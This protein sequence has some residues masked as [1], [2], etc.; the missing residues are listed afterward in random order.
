MSRDIESVT[1]PGV[2]E[3]AP[4]EPGK[5]V[6]E[7]TREGRATHPVKM[8]S[9]EN[10]L[11]PS[12]AGLEAIVADAAAAY[13]Y[14]EMTTPD[15]RAA[16][17][18]VLG[19]SEESIITGNGADGVIYSLGMT[20]LGEGDEAVIPAVTFPVYA[21]VVRAMRARVV[22]SRMDG[23][24]I[25][26]DDVLA[27]IG[28]RTRVLWICNPNNPTGTI[29]ESDRF[30]RFLDR[31]PE[32]VWVVHDEVYHD[33]AERRTFPDALSEVRAGRPNLFCIRSFSKVYGL[34]G[35][36]LGF[37]FGPAELIGLMYRVRPPFDVS[38]MAE[39]AGLAAL[40]DK[41][42]YV[43]TVQLVAEGR[44]FLY[45]ELERLGLSFVPSH[46]NF[47]LVDT[48]KNERQVTEALIDRGIIVRPAGKYGL[49]GHIRVTV[50]LPDQNRRFVEALGAVL[51][52]LP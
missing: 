32:D 11:G 17:A 34:A 35:L 2:R 3:I 43:R 18:G 41:D 21:T 14:P 13:R 30:F 25:D 37:G 6:A 5:S 51:D 46:T 26:L 20:V 48:G 39:K 45:G 19:L 38:V 50:G 52:S 24:G 40:R 22:V 10:A 49:P 4:Y 29:I 36:R 7:V 12:P 28:R 9:N 15:L 33:F 44:R 23:Y 47:V 42:F 1:N 8:A 31:V 27:A 16:L